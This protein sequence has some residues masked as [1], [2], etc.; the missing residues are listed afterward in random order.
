MFS[1][2]MHQY[3]Q[4]Q[5]VDFN[6]IAMKVGGITPQS[7]FPLVGWGRKLLITSTI[8]K[9]DNIIVIEFYCET[10]FP[11]APSNLS[12]GYTFSDSVV[13]NGAS[14]MGFDHK[15]NRD[16]LLGEVITYDDFAEQYITNT[17]S[18]IILDR[19]MEGMN[20]AMVLSDQLM[21]RVNSAWDN[22]TPG[23]KELY[24]VSY[25]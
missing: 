2:E 17:S 24:E 23:N 14:A 3:L 12:L 16:V 7:G 19:A 8:D 1:P 21:D 11:A 6:T 10:V 22:R 5:N 25:N 4:E 15:V 18:R 13:F 9:P 20:D